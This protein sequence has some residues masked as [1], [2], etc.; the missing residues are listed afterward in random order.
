MSEQRA[1]GIPVNPAAIAIFDIDGVVR[2]VSGSYRRALADTVEQFTGQLGE[3]ADRPTPI[4]ID[5]LKSEGHWNNDWEASRELIYRHLEREGQSRSQI[6]LNYDKMVE[7][8]QSRYRG[9]SSDP[10]S[11]EGYI[12]HEPL[13]MT[14]DYLSELT[15]NKIAWGFFS[16]AM[17]DEARYVLRRIGV[18]PLSLVAMEDAP[19]KPDPTGLMQAVQLLTPEPLPVIYAGDTVADMVTITR[20]QEQYPQRQWVAVG[21]LPPHVQQSADYRDRYAQSLTQ[22]GA[23]TVLS[24]IERLDANQVKSLI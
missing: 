24:G 19:G 4:D 2:D 21:I 6:S 8:F 22:A 10:N 3:T 18:N 7:F 16:G 17:Q 13:L 1:D 12:A 5:Q 11:W 15:Q 23:A 20:A 9:R 14:Q